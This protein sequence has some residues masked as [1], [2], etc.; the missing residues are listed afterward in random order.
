VRAVAEDAG[1]V[2]V[3]GVLL[4]PHD[5]VDAKATVRL[6][7]VRLLRLGDLRALAVELLELL[8]LYADG[9]GIDAEAR[10][11]R[12]SIVEPRLPDTDRLWERRKPTVDPWLAPASN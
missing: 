8:V 9:W 11:G 4:T 2:P 1:D 5:E 6:D 3:R 12:R 10:E 7:H